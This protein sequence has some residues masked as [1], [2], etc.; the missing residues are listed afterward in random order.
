MIVLEDIRKDYWMGKEIKVEALKGISL[1]LKEGG[2]YTII[3]PSGSGKSTLLS[4]VG[5]LDKP[6]S[7]RYLLEGKE[8]EKLSDDELASIRN[9]RFGFVFQV[10]NL[11]GPLS[12]LKNVELPFLYSKTHSKDRRKIAYEV[13]KLV[14]LEKR[15]D[16]RPNELSGGE[17]QRVAIARALV[18]DPDIILADE[19]TGNL[20]TATGREIMKIFYN[21]H[22]EGKTI[23]LITHNEENA[24][25][26]ERIISLRDGRI[27]KESGKPQIL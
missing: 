15:I 25:F 3:G 21:L 2:F 26:A 19:P 27:E 5:C 20:D 6:S 10:F 18:N 8:V 9:E 17:Q 16:H 4:I 12:V 24:Q 13:L 1:E 7:G 11:L 23:L 14:G 22:K